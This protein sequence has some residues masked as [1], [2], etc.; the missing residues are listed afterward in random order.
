[1]VKLCFVVS[2]P[3]FFFFN[4]R[5]GVY[6]PEREREREL[7][8]TVFSG[9]CLHCSPFSCHFLSHLD[10]GHIATHQPVLQASRA[11]TWTLISHVR[12]GFLCTVGQ[13]VILILPS[14]HYSAFTRQHSDMKRCS[15]GNSCCRC[16]LSAS[17]LS[18]FSCQL[19]MLNSDWQLGQSF[20]LDCPHLKQTN[21]INKMNLLYVMHADVY[22]FFNLPESACTCW[23]ETGQVWPREQES[24][25]HG[26]RV[27]PQS[28]LHFSVPSGFWACVHIALCVS[29]AGRS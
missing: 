13:P 1:M 11:K 8:K 5:V 25:L 3:F 27:M 7:E 9:A 12:P 28:L 17:Q 26:G 6:V 19:E 23:R 16:L 14:L 2:C 18:F 20:A 4:A 22:I 24:T 29:Q 15:V 21:M 10:P